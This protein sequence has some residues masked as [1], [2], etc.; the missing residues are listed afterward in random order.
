MFRKRWERLRELIRGV[1]SAHLTP[2]S[3]GKAVALG[4]FVGCLPIYGIHLGV[5]IVLARWLRL[6][7][8][9]VYA[10]A[11]EAGDEVLRGV[12]RVLRK[13]FA[14][15]Y[16]VARYGGEEFA[17]VFPAAFVTMP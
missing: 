3:I 8:V 17:I 4:V 9:I 5:C 11:Y 13:N 6:N 12:A 7:E 15:S 14:E 10:G 16:L 1:L 2:L